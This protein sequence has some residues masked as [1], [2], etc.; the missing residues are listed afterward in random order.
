MAAV[1][2]FLYR[3]SYKVKAVGPI[4]PLFASGARRVRTSLLRVLIISFNILPLS[5]TLFSPTASL[6][7]L[8]PAPPEHWQNSFGDIPYLLT[9]PGQ[10]KK[11]RQEIVYPF[12]QKVE[13]VITKQNN[14]PV[15]AA[16][17]VKNGAVRL[18]PAG[19]L[20]PHDLDTRGKRLTLSWIQGFAAEILI[21]LHSG[22]MDTTG[23]NTIR[24]CAEI[25]ERAQGDPWLLDID[26]ITAKLAGGGFRVNYI[27]KLPSRDIEMMP[28]AGEWFLESPF[29]SLHPLE[30][31]QILN[32]KGLPLGFNR[33]FD[34]SSGGYYDLYLE[35]DNI[36]W[37]KK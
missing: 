3:N 2:V 21:R 27:R 16:P 28:G 35:E 24:L 17:L 15:T 13:I 4:N 19:G 33:L 18:P 36:F 34:S 23:I 9:Y 29:S 26:L 22:G 1:P 37:I 11:L 5:C 12:R 6:L 7:I 10:E 30:E 32:L 25:R 20:Y 14:L 31:Q 8:F